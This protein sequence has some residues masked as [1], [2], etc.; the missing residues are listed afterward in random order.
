MSV[1][2]KRSVAFVISFVVMLVSMIYMIGL[3][4]Q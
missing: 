1:F 3:G 2:K 4:V